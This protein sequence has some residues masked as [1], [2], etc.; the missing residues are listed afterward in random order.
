MFLNEGARRQGGR[1]QVKFSLNIF[2]MHVNFFVLERGWDANL[3]SDLQRG[4]PQHGG[5]TRFF[6]SKTREGN[7]FQKAGNI[8]ADITHCVKQKGKKR[9]KIINSAQIVAEILASANICWRLLQNWLKKRH[10]L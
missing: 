1:A 9:R 3:N 5:G 8:N 7:P 6:C 10:F 2:Y 4:G